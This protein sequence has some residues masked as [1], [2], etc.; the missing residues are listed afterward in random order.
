MTA[1]TDVLVIG[2]GPT[3]LMLANL[4]IRSGVSVRILDKKAGL[5]TE[6]RAIVVHAKILELLDKLDLADKVIGEGE[7]LAGIQILAQGKRA[8]TIPFV[9]GEGNRR[10]PYP[11]GLIYGQDQTEHLL[12]G[13]LVETGNQVEWETELLHLEQA[14]DSV[15]AQ[16]CSVDGSEETIEAR[17][18]IGADSSHS[19]VRH[20]LSLGFTGQTYRQSLF[21]A[22]LDMEW[23]LESRQGSIDLTSEGFFLFIPMLGANQFRLFGT[24]PR[25]LVDK[26]TMTVDDVR[27]TLAAQSRVHVN[28]L[29]AHWIS[30]YHTHQRMTEHFRVGHVFLAGDAAHIH[31]PAGGQGM[32]TG[33]G[34]AYNLAWKLALVIK[35][36][37]H[38]TLLDS[39]EAERLPFA[40]AILRGSDLG[41]QLQTGTNLFSRWIKLFVFPQ[42]IRF[43]TPLL[44]GLGRNIFWLFSQLWTNYRSSPAVMESEPKSGKKGLRAG[45]RAPYG[46]FETGP[47]AGKSI[48]SILKGLDHHLLLFAGNK[49][50]PTLANTGELV[51]PLRSLLDTYAVPIHL[52][53]VSAENPGLHKMYETSEPSLFLIRP[54]G[55]IAYHGRANDLGSFKSYLDKLFSQREGQARIMTQGNAPFV[56]DEHAPSS[57]VATDSTLNAKLSTLPSGRSPYPTSTSEDRR[58][59][60]WME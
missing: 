44:P 15:Q 31:S 40:R 2:A 11:Y 37:A 50:D 8:G 17:W 4:L 23:G 51:G 35:G 20:A 41:F 32:N 52:H 53:S 9:N 27:R 7:H 21:V 48:F 57:L 43:L 59:G 12:L 25:E 22:D 1:T 30:V 54:D 28:I 19:P 5:A 29:K 16:V 47:D 26:N 49:L 24:L 6:T 38:E 13:S 39:Y 55:N 45:D 33:L 60:R 36:Q 3:G 10:T 58:A 14:P 42:L 34:D 18:V 46:F 56:T